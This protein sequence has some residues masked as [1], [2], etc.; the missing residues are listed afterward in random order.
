MLTS[1]SLNFVVNTVV[2]T[3]TLV[4]TTKFNET[5]VKYVILKSIQSI[6]PIQQKDKKISNE[7][8]FS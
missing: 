3:N 1:I 6:K 4:F 8:T 7:G 2:I 5:D